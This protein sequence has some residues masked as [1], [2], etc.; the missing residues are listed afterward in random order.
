MINRRSDTDLGNT[1]DIGT[2]AF[3]L[4]LPFHWHPRAGSRVKGLY[5]LLFGWVNPLLTN[6]DSKLFWVLFWVNPETYP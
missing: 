1:L 6:F 3:H 2:L 4:P 5:E